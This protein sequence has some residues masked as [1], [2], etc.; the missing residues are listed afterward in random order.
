[1]M[2][3]RVLIITVFGTEKP[4]WLK[5][6]PELIDASAVIL[7]HYERQMRFKTVLDDGLTVMPKLQMSTG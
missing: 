5:K 1:M 3:F 7:L 4:L 6:I 2:A